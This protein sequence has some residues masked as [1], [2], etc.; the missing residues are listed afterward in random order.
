MGLLDSEPGS[1]LNAVST[2]L[3]DTVEFYRWT[4]SITGKAAGSPVLA[5]P[6]GG[7]GAASP[8]RLLGCCGSEAAPGAGTAAGHWFIRSER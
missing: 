3:N 4:W 6:R 5:R 8:P 7:R 2:A 1:V